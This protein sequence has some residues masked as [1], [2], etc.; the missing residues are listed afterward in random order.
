MENFEGEKS[1]S[2]QTRPMYL[3][4]YPGYW[5]SFLNLLLQSNYKRFF[6]TNIVESTGPQVEERRAAKLQKGGREGDVS[7]TRPT[8]LEKYSG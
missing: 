2:S 1:D 3:E 7:W 6:K 5:Y 8:Y 4:Q